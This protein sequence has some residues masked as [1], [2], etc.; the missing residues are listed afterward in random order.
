MEE[1][2]TLVS[3]KTGVPEGTA[4]Q[5]VEIVVDYLKEKLPAP[6]AGQIDQVLTKGEA[7]KNVDQLSRGL[8]GVLGKK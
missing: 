6:I 1:L 4:R 2:V 3:E 5:A 7:V 8:G